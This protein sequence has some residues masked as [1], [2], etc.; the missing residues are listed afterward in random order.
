MSETGFLRSDIVNGRTRVCGLIGN[1]VEH[2]LS[3]LIHNTL[4]DILGINMIYV[5]CPVKSGMVETAVKGAYE[6]GFLGLNVTVP[7]KIEVMGA[8]CDI[9]HIAKGIG[10]VNTLVL[11]EGG[12][13]GYNTDA[14]GL[15]RALESEGVDISGRD[16]V[17]LGAGGAARAVAFLCADKGASSIYIANRSPDKAEELAGAVNA[18]SGSDALC[19]P[20]SQLKTTSD[21]TAKLCKPI[22]LNNLTHDLDTSDHPGKGLIAIQ[23][24]S[25]G[26]SPRDDEAVTEEKS[27]YDRV[28]YGFDLVYRPADTRFMK[29]VRS[30]GGQCSNGLLMLLYQ[31]VDAFELWNDVR[32][33]EE[34]VRET[35]EILKEKTLQ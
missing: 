31:A 21:R 12:Y 7:H 9:D 24:T 25:V 32:V 11:T 1:P 19:K 3:P 29:N 20:K 8:L 14:S 18:Y 34:A 35:L 28:E 33:P 30:S 13:K 27:F 22:S 17:I 16:V 10:S 2:T 6:L 4:A 23:A 26:L 5:A 15:G